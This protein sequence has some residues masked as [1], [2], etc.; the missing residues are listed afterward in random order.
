MFAIDSV[1][2]NKLRTVLSLLGITIGIFSIISVFTIIDSLE[3]NIR[4]NVEAFG[5]NIVYLEKWP[6][7]PEEG[8]DYKWWKYSNRP[9]P[10]A[11]E[12]QEITEA[13]PTAEA[14]AMSLSFYRTIQFDGASMSS[15]I[16]GATQQYDQMR[17]T[18]VEAGRY[19]TPYES[20]RGARVALVGSTIVEELFGG[21]DPV[22][23]TIKIGASKVEII[24]TLAKE[25]NNM[26]GMS[27]DRQVLVPFQF[28]RTITNPLWS[29][30]SIMIKGP[31]GADKADF[32]AEATAVMRRLRRLGPSVESNFAV[33]ETGAINKQ[34]DSMF[35]VIN[36]AG[37]IIGLFSIL[38]GAFGVANIMFVSVR[39]RTTQIGIQ[40]ALGARP[41]FILLQFTFEAILLSIAGGAVGL[42]LIF[43]GAAIISASTSF[44][45]S[46]S[47]GN[48]VLGLLISSSVGAISGIFPA[49]SAARMQ[50]VKA[51]F[52]T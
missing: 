36:L 12:F 3:S 7:T 44:D 48:I 35:V 20:G 46:L 5:S 11:K 24:G 40:K 50:P 45:V 6:W 38:V 23:K 27:Y 30:P 4:N 28:A 37:G 21:A 16:I 19:F 25:G 34:L 29:N 22:G 52:K 1:V 17:K 39:E 18:E 32:V 14:T 33:N 51:I 9:Q 13:I 42:L 47:L 41:Y 15:E 26:F 31:S 43:M 49:F 10:T 2:I 8:S